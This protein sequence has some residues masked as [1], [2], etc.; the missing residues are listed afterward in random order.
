MFQDSTFGAK[1][2]RWTPKIHTIIGPF[3]LLHKLY[4]VQIPLAA[5]FGNRSLDRLSTHLIYFCT[6][7]KSID[8]LQL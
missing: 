8:S 1:E 7:D 5:P 3:E 4:D 2:E 6:L